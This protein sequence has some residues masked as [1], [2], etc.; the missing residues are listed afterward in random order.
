MEYYNDHVEE[1]IETATCLDCGR[2]CNII[3]EDEGIGPN[4]FWGIPGND[5]QICAS[6]DCCGSEV[7]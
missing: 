1:L 3:Y 2:E 5:V 6:S 4:E 7:D